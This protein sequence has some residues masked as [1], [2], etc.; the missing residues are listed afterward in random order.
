M[1]CRSFIASSTISGNALLSRQPRIISD[2][3]TFRASYDQLVK[4]DLIL[5]RLRMRPSEESLLLDL[6]ERG[7]RLFPSALSQSA[8]RSK[9]FQALLFSSYMLPCTKAVH[10]QHQL[11]KIMNDYQDLGIDRIVTKEDRRNAGMGVYLWQ[12]IED[13]HTQAGLGVVPYPFVLQPFFPNCYDIRVI[14][15]GDYLEAY[16]RHNQHNFR[17]NL[18]CGGSSEPCGLTHEQRELCRNVMAR[19]K[20]P[21]AHIDLM[22]TADNK[23]YLG[24]INLRGGIRGA[25]IRPAEYKDR[26]EALHAGARINAE[27]NKGAENL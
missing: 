26:V 11:L 15:L 18:H 4:G 23:T 9:A 12:S 25:K 3:D 10:D 20:F 19:G 14:I 13:L 24:E 17:N 1:Q 6:T 21:Y 8:C 2:N 27:G 5:G 7:V 16:T 22:V